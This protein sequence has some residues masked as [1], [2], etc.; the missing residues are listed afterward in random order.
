MRTNID[1]LVLWPFILDKQEQPD[2]R[3]EGDWRKEVPLD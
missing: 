2:W 1:H 3:E